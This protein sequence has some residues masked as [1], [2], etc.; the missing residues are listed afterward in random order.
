MTL[1]DAVGTTKAINL[2]NQHYGT[3]CVFDQW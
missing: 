2:T 3:G 1:N